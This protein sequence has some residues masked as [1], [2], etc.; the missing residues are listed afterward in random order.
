MKKRSIC[1]RTLCVLL[2]TVMLL[3]SF[4]ALPVQ[5]ESSEVELAPT[6]EK[7]PTEVSDADTP[8]EISTSN[9]ATE[10]DLIQTIN[11]TSGHIWLEKG[12]QYRIVHDTLNITYVYSYSAAVTVDAG[13]SGI[14]TAAAEGPISLLLYYPGN[15]GLSTI[16]GCSGSVLDTD[17]TIDLSQNQV[18][19]SPGRE[20]VLMHD[21][22]EVLNV[23]SSNS[24]AVAVNSAS[25]IAET[26]TPGTASLFYSYYKAILSL[27]GPI[28]QHM[29]IVVM[30]TECTQSIR[31]VWHLAVAAP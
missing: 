7:I 31:Q 5:A 22:R 24:S 2:S 23:T 3:F 27:C 29:N 15:D 8:A 1:L 11:V 16:T 26:S 30:K 12:Q 18:L 9:E 25:T 14:I 21:G 13:E 20:Y 6:T 19:V 17:G 10:A 4:S 28:V